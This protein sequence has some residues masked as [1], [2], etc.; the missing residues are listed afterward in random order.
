VA[1]SA[2]YSCTKL[3]A[4]LTITTAMIAQPSWDIWP[5]KASTRRDPE[6]QGEEVQELGGE[7]AW[8]AG[9]AGLGSRFGPA[10]ASRAAASWWER[11]PASTPSTTSAGSVASRGSDTSPRIAVGT[12]G[13]P[14]RHQRSPLRRVGVVSVVVFMT[15]PWS[16]WRPAGRAEGPVEKGQ[17]DPARPLARLPRLGGNTGAANAHTLAMTLDLRGLTVPLLVA[18]T[19]VAMARL[20]PGELIEVLTSDPDS[21]RDLPVW[22]RATGNRLVEQT[23]GTGWYRFILQ[24]R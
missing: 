13:P 8:E 20:R 23:Q 10:W 12:S 6:Q 7:L 17:P 24:K 19:A 18:R 3:K 1:R 5:T 2:R 15:R 21:V 4:P 22:A 11:P 14:A 16:R 9:P